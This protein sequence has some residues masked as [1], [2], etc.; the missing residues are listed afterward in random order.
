MEKKNHFFKSEEISETIRPSY[1]YLER[2]CE[3]GL[4]KCYLGSTRSM[5]GELQQAPSE[6]FSSLLILE[7]SLKNYPFSETTKKV[8]KVCEKQLQDGH[9]NFFIDRNILPDDAETTS[10][11][12]S[13]LLELGKL[14]KESIEKVLDEIISNVNN[15]GIIQVYFQPEK[16]GRPNRV[17]HVS[18]SNIL[19][20]LN[21]ADREAQ[22]SEDFVYKVL[23]DQSYLAG[24]RYYH[25]PDA[26]LYFLSR[27]MKFPRMKEK[28][29]DL[30]CDRLQSRIGCS[31][32]PLDL[33]MR[34][35]AAQRLNLDNKEEK[36][37]L[38]TLKNDDG[39]WPIDSIYH[40][41]SK[42]GYF[43]SSYIST[44]FA[45]EALKE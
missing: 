40:Y 41:G 32:F 6:I 28:F 4:Y 20:L 24:S 16:F 18:I 7:T 27:L 3:N 11:G 15:E 9:L 45:I 30:L 35:T 22:I 14:Q 8:V 37:K 12:L 26:F 1:E 23:A 38:K 44:S 2:S 21:L 36:E 5:T 33:A 31:N 17:D 34:I 42:I 25:S 19:Y 29:Y 43:G 13:I 10:Y 39:S